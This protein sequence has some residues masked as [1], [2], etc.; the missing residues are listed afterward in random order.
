MTDDRLKT[1]RSSWL[2]GK[3]R[4]KLRRRDILLE[5]GDYYPDP[6][7]NR[8]TVPAGSRNE[9]QRVHVSAKYISFRHHLLLLVV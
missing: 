5:I 3:K 9:A 8:M 7:Q 2:G 4:H 6:E 1:K